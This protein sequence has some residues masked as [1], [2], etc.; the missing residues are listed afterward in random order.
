MRG[1]MSGGNQCVRSAVTGSLGHVLRPTALT[2]LSHI[3]ASLSNTLT[4]DVSELRVAACHRVRRRSSR[5]I[6]KLGG[7]LEAPSSK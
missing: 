3:V 2:P 4:M 1:R 7:R 5:R 6:S